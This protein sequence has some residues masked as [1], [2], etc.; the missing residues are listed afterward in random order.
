MKKIL[1]SA[2][3]AVILCSIGSLQSCSLDN[4]EEPSATLTGALIDSETNANVPCQYQ[5]GSRIR[6]YEFYNG[7]WAT[8]PNDFYTRQDGTFTNQA[9]FPAK[10]R[11]EVE[12]PFETPAPVEMEISGT[13]ELKIQVLPFLRLTASATAAGSSVNMTATVAKTSNKHNI[14]AVEFYCG[15][16]PYVDK[17]T[18]NSKKEMDLTGKTDA[19]IVS[20]TFSASFDGL[21]SGKTYYF[22]VG[23]LGENSGNYYNYSTVMEVKIP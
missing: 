18:F 9:I 2:F 17:S 7:A 10:Y 13:K 22:R 16:T 20:T 5:N 11:V 6:L 14:K 21:T 12:G 23:A 3:L 1:F 15:V 19:E 4:Y 8:Q